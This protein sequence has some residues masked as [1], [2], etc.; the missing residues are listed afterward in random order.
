MFLIKDCLLKCG[1]CI[2]IFRS[3]FVIIFFFNYKFKFIFENFNIVK[4]CCYFEFK[5]KVLVIVEVKISI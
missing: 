2:Y 5:L 1:V 3:Y 4:F